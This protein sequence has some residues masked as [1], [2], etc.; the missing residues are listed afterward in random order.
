L[1]IDR[2]VAGMTTGGHGKASH[3][4]GLVVDFG[5]TATAAVTVVDGSAT[6]L[7]IDGDSAMPSSVFLD[8]TRGLVAGRLADSQRL[9]DP[10][11]YE[12][13]PKRRLG[14]ASVLLGG[15]EVDPVDLVA[16]V[17]G[18]I[19][20]Q[21]IIQQAGV[22]PAWLRMT[23][24]AL[25]GDQRK[26][27]LTKVA[28]RAGLPDPE[29]LAEPIAA[30][31]Y[32]NQATQIPDS[33]LVGVFDLGGGTF[34]AA[35]I[36]RSGDDYTVVASGGHSNLGG[37][38]F[39][40]ALLRYIGRT[41]IAPVD[42]GVW[43]NLQDP[44]D[45]Q[46][47]RHASDLM[48]RV[49]AAKIGLSTWDS[50]HVFLPVLSVDIEV[51]RAQFE[52]LVVD[53]VRRAAEL[54]R[55]T[56]QV[57]GV[58]PSD[59][60]QL[61]L[62]G[63][64][65]RAPIVA[66]VVG[67]ELNLVPVM[68]GNPKLVVVQ[69][70]ANWVPPPAAEPC[71]SCGLP[72]ATMGQPCPECAVPLQAPLIETASRIGLSYTFPSTGISRRRTGVAVDEGTDVVRVVGHGERDVPVSELGSPISDGPVQRAVNFTPSPAYRLY[73]QAQTHRE[74]KGRLNDVSESLRQRSIGARRSFALAAAGL[75]DVDGV[76]RAGLR[77][78]ERD[79]L[80]IHAHLANGEKGKALAMLC[81]LQPDRYPAKV[82]RIVAC[83][84]AV[85]GSGD[86]EMVARIRRQL[87]PWK[88]DAIAQLLLTLLDSGSSLAELSSST[89]GLD[90]LAGAEPTYETWRAVAVAR[91]LAAGPSRGPRPYG[92]FMADVAQ[93]PGNDLAVAVARAA[94]ESREHPQTATLAPAVVAHL[95]PALLDDLI[96][97]GAVGPDL[98][99]AI[100]ARRDRT[101][102]R[103]RLDPASLS[104]AD[105]AALGFTFER[106]RR[107]LVAGQPLDP[108]DDGPR[109]QRL[110][111]LKRLR[112]GD[113][114]VVDRLLELLAP[115]LRVV[116]RAVGVSLRSQTLDATAVADRSTWPTLAHL[117]RTDAIATAPAEVHPL[118]EWA[119][120]CSALAALQRDD[121]ATAATDASRCLRTAAGANQTEGCILLAWAQHQMD[122]DEAAV[123][124]LGRA[125]AEDN[126]PTLIT[127]FGVLAAAVPPGRA[128]SELTAIAR[129]GRTQAARTI[130]ARA[131]LRPWLGLGPLDADRPG[132][133]PT[134]LVEA[135][136][137]LV[138]ADTE[139][140]AHV[141]FLSVLVFADASWVTKSSPKASPHTKTLEQRT[142]MALA[143]GPSAGA[144]ELANQLSKG[145]ADLAR[146]SRDQLVTRAVERL[147]INPSD[148][149]ALAWA[150]ALLYENVPL[151]V[152]A[153]AALVVVILGA[154]TR[155]PVSRRLLVDRLRQGRESL[156]QSPESELQT[157]LEVAASR[158]AEAAAAEL[159][160]QRKQIEYAHSVLWQLAFVGPAVM[161]PWSVAAT[162]QL[163]NM[164]GYLTDLLVETPGQQGKDRLDAVSQRIAATKAAV[165]GAHN[166]N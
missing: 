130:A 33:R 3:E 11:R 32:Y 12:P 145:N 88:N 154:P 28:D 79:W 23:H 101:Y 150:N 81:D 51:T 55:S 60:A 56:I 141:D 69:G 72:E 136:R 90:E 14:E 64:S 146:R 152:P 119:N 100:D 162:K 76:R 135:L 132:P 94:I 123:A 68:L 47:R 84:S 37:V 143:S 139:L 6:P 106:L 86:Q 54:M 93:V 5:T 166:V 26:A 30:C 15:Q 78:S 155:D 92:F 73:R 95:E 122:Q 138:W 96:D 27:M 42:A 19:A 65:S 22:S 151:D 70:A 148:W 133:P 107:Q 59:L 126:H 74:E 128:V 2:K 103:A 157:M 41:I 34:D 45:Q 113:A 18:A 87:E 149:T 38:D 82:T 67:E 8:E 53:D 35:V 66:R 112:D 13:Y 83:W 89:D 48:E 147:G 160:G 75:G 117:T 57:A 43:E 127:N 99:P 39:D 80:L 71:W 97:C 98:L 24:P 16:A 36:Q 144:H 49:R 110:A 116:A 9:S 137:S 134:D 153:L 31:L 10:R 125:L 111:L 91:W 61:Y 109:V 77:P 105:V 62:V 1:G 121:W 108:A 29:L 159:E 140:A 165:N 50:A 161:R 46:W 163:D 63:G 158:L 129:Y 114:G 118:T 40:A 102:L 25:W 115:D 164:A 124:T 131:A 142:L 7:F 17:V 20:R 85:S 52:E 156:A 21:A 44:P 120:L 104:D 4:W 58:T